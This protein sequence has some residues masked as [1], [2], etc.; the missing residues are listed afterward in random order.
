MGI[1]LWP[2]TLTVMLKLSCVVTEFLVAGLHLLH[3]IYVN[4]S[5]YL[6]LSVPCVLCSDT[7]NKMDTCLKHIY[8]LGVSLGVLRSFVPNSVLA[9]YV[10]GVIKA[11]S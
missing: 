6:L 1:I 9:T 4:I 7:G 2:P 5:S 8:L 11:S 3:S 10:D